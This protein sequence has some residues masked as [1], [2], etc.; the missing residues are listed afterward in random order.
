MI[1]KCDVLIIGGGVAGTM[2]AISAARRGCTVTLLE[3]SGCLGG[4]WTAGLVGFTLD[5]YHKCALLDEFLNNVNKELENNTATLF[6]THKYV[7]E[8]MCKKENIRIVYFAQVFDVNSEKG[9]IKRVKYI[10][11]SLVREIEPKITIDCTGDGD[12]AAMI[13]CDFDFGRPQDGKTQPMSMIALLT[14]INEEK[15]EKYIASREK[16]F[17]EPRNN[18]K[19]LLKKTNISVSLGSASI[20]PLVQN[21][22]IL[23]MNQE[24]GKN[25]CNAD[26]VTTATFDARKEVYEFVKQ[27]KLNYPEYFRDIMLISTPETI[28]VRESR[29]IH[30]KYTV[31]L[32]DMIEGK[33]HDDSIC[34]VHYWPDIHSPEKDEK[35]FSDGGLKISPYDIPF[36]ALLPIGT[37]NFMV[38]GR[39]I[40]GDF[41]AHSSYRVMGNMAAVGDAAG[42]VAAKAI[43]TNTPVSQIEY[44]KNNF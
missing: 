3:R 7:L 10:S 28:G 35:G 19:E 40:G 42:K 23:S 20:V 11:K 36:R 14:G 26:D 37:E 15:A 5:G 16:P 32:E 29:R 38:A 24:Y 22:Y 1:E 31:S 18:L 44:N 34:T 9:I 27:L 17:W 41:Y 12:I 33:H 39:S 21:I 30:C 2:A 25:A 43:K 6:E 4:M 8:Q 13:G